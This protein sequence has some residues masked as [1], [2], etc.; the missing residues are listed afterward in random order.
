M[1][2]GFRTG[3]WTD[4]ALRCGTACHAVIHHPVIKRPDA[5]Y[6]TVQA[7]QSRKAE[8]ESIDSLIISA[9]GTV[10]KNAA[11]SVFPRSQIFDR[12]STIIIR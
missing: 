12:R 1:S 7:R 10:H 2:R 4:T 3:L 9:Q 8:E 5:L 6:P 11:E